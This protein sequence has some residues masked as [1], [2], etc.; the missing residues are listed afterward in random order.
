[1][2]ALTA[3]LSGATP[4]SEPACGSA[5]TAR[6]RSGC[7]AGSEPSGVSRSP[8]QAPT[9]G[10]GPATAACCEHG[11]SHRLAVRRRR[12]GSAAVR[13]RP[14]VSADAPARTGCPGARRSRTSGV[15]PEAL[16][17]RYSVTFGKRHQIGGSFSWLEKRSC[18]EDPHASGAAG[19]GLR[20]TAAQDQA[21]PTWPAGTPRSPPTS[22]TPSP[23]CP[24]PRSTRTT[25][26]RAPRRLPS[27]LT[28]LPIVPELRT[29]ASRLP[30][31]SPLGALMPAHTAG[32]YDYTR[33]LRRTD[34]ALAPLL[35]TGVDQSVTSLTRWPATSPRRC[36]PSTASSSGSTPTRPPPRR[37]SGVSPPPP[38]WPGGRAPCHRRPPP[39]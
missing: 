34:A 4:P 20:R 39:W 19:P 17:E 31:G 33:V 15:L 13:S 11:S 6:D 29:T 37:C 32:R 22:R 1:M 24:T 8:P 12:S 9:L 38:P 21:G 2:P 26:S 7:R 25:R 5:S 36:R 10:S 18:V 30:R 35:P 28:R 14:H 23:T 16:V 27:D 3:D